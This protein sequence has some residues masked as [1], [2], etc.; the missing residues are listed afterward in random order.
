MGTARRISGVKWGWE[1][2]G[3]APV[4]AVAI[5]DLWRAL[6]MAR[7]FR[8]AKIV[9]SRPLIAGPTKQPGIFER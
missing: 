3:R 9:Y 7:H 1:P 8:K 2:R 5:N 6:K 4:E